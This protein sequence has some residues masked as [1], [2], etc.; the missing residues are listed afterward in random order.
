MICSPFAKDM[1][2]VLITGGSRGIG[3]D[4]VR[5]LSEQGY[6]VYFFYKNSDEKAN[7][8]SMETGATP[9]KCDVSKESDVER[10]FEILHQKCYK[11]DVLI[12]NAGISAIKPFLDVSAEE[13]REMM[14]V[15]L[16]G[17]FYCTK[18]A[19]RDML[20]EK[21][22]RIVNVSSMWGQV[23]ASCEVPYSAA[24][25]GLIGMTKA[26]AKELGPSGITVNCVC[27]GFINTDMNKELPTSVVEEIVEEIPM[28]RTG[29]CRDVTELVAFL[30]SQEAE[31]ITGQIIG[32]NGGIVI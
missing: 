6:G 13:W 7:A 23:G 18:H 26:L 1:K 17:A 11:I 16:D 22:G 27:P 24:K 32:V 20:K 28:G 3:A 19:A 21:W 8:L 5:K 15:T 14:A 10:A 12:N 4:L 30:V 2:N 31:Y 29:S 9:I 25:S